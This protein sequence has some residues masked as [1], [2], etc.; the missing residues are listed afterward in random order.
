MG[1]TVIKNQPVALNV[2]DPNN[3]CYGFDERYCQLAQHGDSWALQFGAALCTAD[4]VTCGDFTCGS[5]TVAA[6]WFSNDSGTL[7]QGWVYGGIN[8]PQMTHVVGMTNYLQQ[9]GILTALNTYKVVFTIKR[10]TSPLIEIV[11]SVTPYAGTTPGTAVTEAGTYTQYIVATDTQLK[12]L[13]SSDFDGAITNIKVYQVQTSYRAFLADSNGT[14]VGVGVDKVAFSN[15]LV[16]FSS[17]WAAFGGG[18]PVPDGCYTF[19]IADGADV[20]GCCDTEPFGDLITN[21]SF[22]V[23][24]G[25]ALGAGW[26]IGAGVAT[27]AVGIGGVLSQTLCAMTIDKTYNVVITVSGRT[28]GSINVSLAGTLVTTISS[29][30]TFNVSGIPNATGGDISIAADAAFDGSVDNISVTLAFASY[31]KSD[32]GPCYDLKTTHDCTR[33]AEWTNEENAFGMNYTDPLFLPALHHRLRTKLLLEEPSYPGEK[34]KYTDSAGNKKTLFFSS[35]EQFKVR[36]DF[37]PLYLQR[38]LSI[39]HGHDSFFIDGVQ[40][41]V[42]NTDL[43]PA[44]VKY[45]KVWLVEMDMQATP[46]HEQNFNCA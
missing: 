4:L 30:G 20:G 25:W 46:Q 42:Q 34:E 38:A 44:F 5:S 28:S 32:Y 35:V 10:V 22:S 17:T 33:L 16:H 23:G 40:Y 27:H 45:K 21:G 12:F 13:P 26:T 14:N 1:I 29:N 7:L 2:T 8:N 36:F 41:D 31:P 3:G 43:V 15:G 19:Y 24:T 9:N 18:S 11:G 37:L 39:A 6:N